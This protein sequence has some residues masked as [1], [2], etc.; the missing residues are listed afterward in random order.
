MELRRRS[1]IGALL[2]APAIIRTPGLLMP[3]KPWSPWIYQENSYSR[4][5]FVIP[6][7]AGLVQWGD[8][9]LHASFQLVGGFNLAGERELMSL[10]SWVFG[11]YAA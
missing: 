9:A 6:P 10:P 11:D 4:G 1:L 5:Y 7:D 3:V 8:S 2:A